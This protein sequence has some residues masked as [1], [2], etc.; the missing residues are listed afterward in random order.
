[1][2]TCMCVWYVCVHVCVWYVC[3][4]VALKI[5]P[6]WLYLDFVFKQVYLIEFSKPPLKDQ[7]VTLP[8]VRPFLTSYNSHAVTQI[9]P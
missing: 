6:L 9:L 8:E 7:S 3:C 5:Y 2:R 4:G 1:M